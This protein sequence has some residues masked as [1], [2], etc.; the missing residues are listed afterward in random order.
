MYYAK[1]VRLV[2][3]ITVLCKFNI[4]TPNIK[5]KYEIF[6]LFVASLEM[7]SM[8]YDLGYQPSTVATRIQVQKKVIGK[9]RAEST[10]LQFHSPGAVGKGAL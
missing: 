8:I 5:T 1:N 10:L 7:F 9:E 3:W 2:F 6:F 4:Y